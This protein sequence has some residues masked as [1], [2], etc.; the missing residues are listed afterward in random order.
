MSQR[1][2]G[3]LACKILGIYMMMQGLNVLANVAAVH[4]TTPG[5]LA[6]QNPMTVVFP[7]L[8]LIAFGIVFWLSSDKLAGI[9]I[10]SESKLAGD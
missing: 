5:Q 7:F 9:M 4:A 8:F 3:S 6:T 1:E 10:K 2:V